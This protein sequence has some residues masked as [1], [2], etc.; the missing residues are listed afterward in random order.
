MCSFLNRLPKAAF[1]AALA[2]FLGL[3]MVAAGASVFL[4]CVVTCGLAL[5]LTG[6]VCVD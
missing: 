4:A 3:L 1:T 5:A 6:D 2:A